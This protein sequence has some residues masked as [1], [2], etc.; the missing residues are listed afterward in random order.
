MKLLQRVYLTPIVFTA[1]ACSA[2]PASSARVSEANDSGSADLDSGG[3]RGMGLSGPALSETSS[4]I[5]GAKGSNAETEPSLARAPNGHMLVAFT[6]YRGNS[7]STV[8]YVW[9]EDGG[10]SWTQPS[11]FEP[12]TGGYGVYGNVTTAFDTDGR[13]VISFVASE[14]DLNLNRKNTLVV[15]ARTEPGGKDFVLGK[16]LAFASE[17]YR[18]WILAPADGSVWVAAAAGP[19]P[20]KLQ[21][22]RAKKGESTFQE[23]TV[24]PIASIRSEARPVLCAN[25]NSVYLVGY[26]LQESPRILVA[27][28]HQVA[29]G[30][31]TFASLGTISAADQPLIDG[32]LH[33]AASGDELWIAYGSG[34][35]ATG[36]NA[37]TP[38]NK[39]AY[40]AYSS[41]SGKSFAS[42]KNFQNQVALGSMPTLARDAL[43]RIHTFMYGAP[44][45]DTDG[46]FY[47]G[48]WS[49]D[50]ARIELKKQGYARITKQRGGP[51]WIGDYIQA[52]AVADGIGLVYSDNEGTASHI[53]FVGVR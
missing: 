44:D 6:A 17:I 50:G 41:D 24:P 34:P 9:S 36:G 46:E 12:K 32:N 28:G 19:S 22:L 1:L 15:T 43:G 21:V 52:A 16:P 45:F 51:R 7:P 4:I 29:L 49:K 11:Y 14:L 26:G 25:E 2:T 27:T 42:W 48:L 40:V 47:S 10:I 37:Q 20:Y 13:A 3:M 23:V 5:S 30:G 31:S 35:L 39:Q 33:C 18:P 53:R 38:S 8:G